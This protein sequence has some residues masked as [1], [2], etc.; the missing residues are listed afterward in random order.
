[1]K[2][3]LIRLAVAAGLALAAAGAASAATFVAPADGSP[4][5]T[6]LSG[7]TSTD[8]VMFAAMV[9]TDANSICD[10][11]GGAPDVYTT[12]AQLTPG[13]L[14]ANF[15]VV[16]KPKG[17]IAGLNNAA[18]QA[19]RKYSGGSGSGIGNVA[20]GAA[21][22]PDNA[23]DRQWT[24]MNPANC[25]QVAGGGGGGATG[26]Q[27]YNLYINCPSDVG[28][29][30]KGGISDEEPILLG[31]TAT[32]LGQLTTTS[33]IAV[34]FAPV[35]STALFNALQTAEHGVANGIDDQSNMPN[36]SSSTLRGIFLG[37]ITSRSFLFAN[38]A[39]DAGAAVALPAAPSG[40]SN[41]FICRRGNS[42]GT[43]TGFGIQYLHQ[44]CGTAGNGDPTLSFVG[45][46]T[47]SC[48]ASGCGWGTTPVTDRVF[49]GTGSQDVINCM[50]AHSV[51]GDYAIGV[52]T[53]EYAPNDAA[54]AAYRHVKV[55]GVAP[56]LENMQAG[57]WDFF[58][59][60]A[61]NVPNN[62]APNFPNVT[63]DQSLI[64][65]AIQSAF[66]AP[67]LLQVALIQQGT[68]TGGAAWWGGA[69]AIPTLA[70]SSPA[71]QGQ[72]SL[73]ALVQSTPVNSQ[74]R[75]KSYGGGLNNC[76][77]AWNGARTLVPVDTASY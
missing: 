49:A 56:S 59:E 1:M 27:A 75:A 73:H 36:M 15:A 51:A 40:S 5:L 46:T 72:A 25:Q 77:P 66:K 14:I 20:S 17:T 31:A 10:S 76:N 63:N 60:D 16:C 61:F 42:S 53:T 43:Q 21:V 13:V 69:M 35:V 67:A 28:Q 11:T 23:N 24:T 7:A 32:Q 50:N 8:G 52:L 9:G 22:A 26:L 45:A 68:S 54:N 6:D 41:I 18:I 3:N 70:T 71:P 37:N 57:A 2:L 4:N 62:T 55:D 19:V 30:T 65:A 58:T 12:E 29:V 48:T 47:A 34:D 64:T 44:G 38:P 74:T 39:G 33:G